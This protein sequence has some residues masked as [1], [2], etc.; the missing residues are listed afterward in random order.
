MSPTFARPPKG[1]ATSKFWINDRLDLDE[2]PNFELSLNYQKIFGKS[3]SQ[4]WGLVPKEIH[5]ES[6]A[7]GIN[8]IENKAYFSGKLHP[9]EICDPVSFIEEYLECVRANIQAINKDLLNADLD[10][11]LGFWRMQGKISRQIKLVRSQTIQ[12]LQDQI[13]FS[14]IN[15]LF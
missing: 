10:Y 14:D 13:V 4:V 7:H 15:K 9:P 8:I 2:D 6:F 5:E 11:T 1:S 3:H 12:G